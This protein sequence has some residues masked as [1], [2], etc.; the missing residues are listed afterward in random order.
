VT[1][2]GCESGQFRETLRRATRHAEQ[3][4]ALEISGVNAPRRTGRGCGT[5]P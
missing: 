4:E 2:C 3:A 1:N 5:D